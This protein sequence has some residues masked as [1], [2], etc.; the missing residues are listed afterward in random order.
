[1]TM[2]ALLGKPGVLSP[3]ISASLIRISVRDEVLAPESLTEV[4]LLVRGRLKKLDAQIVIRKIVGSN[5]VPLSAPVESSRQSIL[6]TAATPI[7]SI[8][9]I[10]SAPRYAGLYRVDIESDGSSI[11]ENLPSLIVQRT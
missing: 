7:E 1:M 3:P 5:G 2:G 10:I 9:V 4:Q 8:A 6:V 11:A